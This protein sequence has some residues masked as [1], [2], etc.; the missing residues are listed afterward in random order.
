MDRCHNDNQ[1]ACFV[2]NEDAALEF[3]AFFGFLGESGVWNL[4]RFV[5]GTTVP[6]QNS[7]SSGGH[8][9]ASRS[10][11]SDKN[12]LCFNADEHCQICELGRID[13]KSSKKWLADPSLLLPKPH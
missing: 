1:E 11:G 12:V 13:H 3:V 6:F 9:D 10:S 8:H 2:D 4:C 5:E 7:A